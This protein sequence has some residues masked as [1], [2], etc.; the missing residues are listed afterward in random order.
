MKAPAALTGIL[1]AGLALAAGAMTG[2]LLAGLALAAGTTATVSWV[3]PTQHVDGS[4]LPL[5]D[6]A[7]ST[8]KWSGGSLDVAGPAT[9]ATVPVP[10]GDRVF[11][12][13]VTTKAGAKYP[14]VASD[15]SDAVTYASGVTCRPK[16]PTAVEVS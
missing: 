15:D 1:Q 11:S 6:I 16:A 13:S 4:A 8:I 7:K 2:I 10:C 9:T 14:S 12:V 5:S 3:M